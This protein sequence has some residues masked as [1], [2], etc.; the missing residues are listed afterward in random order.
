MIT[1]ETRLRRPGMPDTTAETALLDQNEHEAARRIA[2]AA[3]DALFALRQSWPDPTNTKGLRDCGDRTSHALICRLLM[4]A[5]PDDAILSE[6]GK[7]DLARLEHRRVWIVD[8]LDGTREFSEGRDDWAV[9]VALAVDRVPVVGAVALPALGLTFDTGT[10]PS[11]HGLP[12]QQLRIVVSRTRPPS[13]AFVIAQLL[14][15]E[16]IE[17]GSAGA[18]T[19]AVVRGNADIYLHAG[20]QY[21]WDSAAPVAVALAAGLHVSWLDGSPL[22]YNQPNPWLPDQIVCRRE[23]AAQVLAACR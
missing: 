22:R 19:M 21:E 2:T 3:G 15:A 5:Y 7:D 13:V 6:E 16:V 18:K 20:G 4:D 23:L 9:H 11:P 8:P 17:M 10:P 1:S 12:Q 14:G